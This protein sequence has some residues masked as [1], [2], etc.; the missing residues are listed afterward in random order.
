MFDAK[1]WLYGL[2]VKIQCHYIILYPLFVNYDYVCYDLTNESV[3][4]IPD[5][6]ALVFATFEWPSLYNHSLWLIGNDQLHTRRD[7]RR[8][9]IVSRPFCEKRWEGY[10]AC[11]RWPHKI[12]C[13]HKNLLLRQCIAN[14][15]N[16][17]MHAHTCKVDTSPPKQDLYGYGDQAAAAQSENTDI[18]TIQWE[19]IHT[20]GTN[21]RTSVLHVQTFQCET[22]SFC[23]PLCSPQDIFRESTRTST[24]VSKV[25]NIIQTQKVC[26]MHTHTQRLH[27]AVS[28]AIV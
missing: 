25:K 19:N 15:H 6:Q 24:D 7:Y 12:Y 1:W 16:T 3:D 11:I 5:G 2:S 8:L 10:S 23:M 28:R 21:A 17:C 14:T 22:K 18:S 4:I 13:I 27:I 9:S 20:I 26:L